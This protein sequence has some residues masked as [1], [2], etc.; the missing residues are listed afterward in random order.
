MAD[1]SSRGRR[2][3]GGEP[4]LVDNMRLAPSIKWPCEVADPVCTLK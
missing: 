1:S 3:E 4:A 2:K